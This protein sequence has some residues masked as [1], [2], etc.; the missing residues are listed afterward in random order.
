MTNDDSTSTGAGSRL[1]V[2]LV[3]SVA[4]T[5]PALPAAAGG[6]TLVS[7][8]SPADKFPSS[9]QNEPAV[10]V[11]ANHPNI[12]AVGANDNIDSAPRPICL[13]PVFGPGVAGIYFSFDSGATW[14]QPT[15]TGLTARHCD[16]TAVCAAEMGPIGTVPW[17]SESGLQTAGDPALAFG[18]VRGADGSFSW[19]NGS[20]LYYAS[21]AYNL[22]GS[23]GYSANNGDAEF[24]VSRT[25]NV[26]AAAANDKGAWLPPVI[27]SKLSPN[28]FNDKEQIWADNAE[29]S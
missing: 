12:L 17:Y 8:G 2:L 29:S 25:D 18:P 13:C 9:S 4:M 10:A 11:D 19:A 7:V 22:G 20:R 24:T 5:I 6:D 14:T 28:A 15:Y 1:V 16:E 27:V 26:A 3:L 23:P 21:L